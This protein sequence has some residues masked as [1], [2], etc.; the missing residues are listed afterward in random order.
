MNVSAEVADKTR[1]IYGGT[2]PSPNP[3]PLLHIPTSYLLLCLCI[4]IFSPPSKEDIV[5]VI[6]NVEK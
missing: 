1:I 5:F 6:D 4:I 2:F 3:P